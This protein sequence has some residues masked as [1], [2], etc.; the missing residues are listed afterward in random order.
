MVRWPWQRD[1]APPTEGAL[2]R[3]RAEKDYASLQERRKE[4]E[5][6]GSSL[7]ELRTE[8]HFGQK[9]EASWKERLG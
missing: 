8:N 4:A 5:R 1:P 9:I 7:R 3:A 6:I 2:A